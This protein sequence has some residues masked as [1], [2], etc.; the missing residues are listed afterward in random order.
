MFD[1]RSTS[2]TNATY[3][4]PGG[5]PSEGGR[6]T[7]YTDRYFYSGSGGD[8]AFGF[9]GAYNNIRDGA[10][11]SANGNT[12]QNGGGGGGALNSNFSQN[13]TGG[14]GGAGIVVIE[15]YQ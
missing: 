11:I 3:V 10:Q 8:S 4:I 12:G 2:T 1:T 13:R 9:G 15:E 14:A 6:R 7:R 5:Y